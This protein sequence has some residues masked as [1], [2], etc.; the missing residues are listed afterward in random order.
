[1]A[2]LAARSDIRSAGVVNNLPVSGAG[3]TTWLRIENE[4][5]P[6]GEPPEVGYRAAS[7]GYFSTVHI[8]ILEGRGL[9]DSDT[10]DSLK[11]TVVNRALANR[12][13]PR[14]AVGRRIRIGPNPKAPWRTIVGVV[15]NVR[16]IGPEVEP[17]PELFLPYRQDVNGDMSLAVRGDGE[18]AALGGAIRDTLR[19][20]DPSVTL[21]RMR[22]MSELV[23]EHLAPRRLALVLVEGFAGVALALALIGIYGVLSYTVSQRVPEIGVRM[24]LGATPSGIL[25][26]TIGDGLRL[27]VPGVVLGIVGALLLTRLARAVL[28]NVSPG[29]PAS[30]AVLS[31]AVFVTALTACYLPARRAARID[32]ISAIRME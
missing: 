5:Q 1:L 15:G 17:A 8:P 9:A 16:H 3:W 14:G 27:A 32:P 4:P 23:D 6:P 13:F 7:P 29:D 22:A 12:F 24:A 31:A 21:W 10:Q 11:V 26:M 28:F 18:T 2:R 30:Y 25:R 19:A 20:I